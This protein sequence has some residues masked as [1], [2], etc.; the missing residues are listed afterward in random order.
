M[1]CSDEA[2][3]TKVTTMFLYADEFRSSRLCA[4]R[5]EIFARPVIYTKVRIGKQSHHTLSLP[6]DKA[7]TIRIFTTKPEEVF[8]SDISKFD[9]NVPN[10][11]ESQLRSHIEKAR[12][13]KINLN[14]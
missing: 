5:I 1:G 12:H 11:E 7:R 14:P 6:A 13:L 2:M 9:P 4:V 3:T 10:D 8:I